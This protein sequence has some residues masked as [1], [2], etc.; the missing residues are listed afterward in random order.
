MSKENEEEKKS[1]TE[2]E[3]FHFTIEIGLS[4][5]VKWKWKWKMYGKYPVK[6]ISL[7]INNFWIMVQLNH[8]LLDAINVFASSTKSIIKLNAGKNHL[9]FPI[10]NKF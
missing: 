6:E 8:S 7:T 10:K 1:S 3:E 5:L 2:H 9:K 4:K